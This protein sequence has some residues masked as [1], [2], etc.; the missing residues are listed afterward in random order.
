MTVHYPALRSLAVVILLALV[1]VGCGDDAKPSFD[2]DAVVA[3]L[4]GLNVTGTTNQLDPALLEDARNICTRPL[5]DGTIALIKVSIGQGTAAILR[6]GCPDR[7][8]EVVAK[9]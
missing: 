4:N 2:E 3:F 7:V 6:A 9:G 8:D 1:G 5:D